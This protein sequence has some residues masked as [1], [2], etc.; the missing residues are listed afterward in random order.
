MT[1]MLESEVY[2][3]TPRCGH[4]QLIVVDRKPRYQDPFRCTSCGVETEHVRVEEYSQASMPDPAPPP[5]PTPPPAPKKP[6]PQPPLERPTP[7]QQDLRTIPARIIDACDG[8][9]EQ[10]KRVMAVVAPA[11]VVVSRTRSDL[12]RVVTLLEATRMVMNRHLSLLCAETGRSTKDMMKAIEREI[13][14]QRLELLR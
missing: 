1:V 3:V 11:A 9:L 13:V 12:E 5:E 7:M 2:L 10:A 6:K 4:Q 8:D 14:D